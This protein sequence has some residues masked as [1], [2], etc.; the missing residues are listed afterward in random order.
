MKTSE[1]FAGRWLVTG[2]AGFI[3]SHLV[4]R[5]LREGAEVVG[6]DNL[7]TGFRSNLEGVRNAVG[8][9]WDRF[10]FI[11]GDIR[12]NEVCRSAMRGIDYV[13]HEAALGSVPRSINA[14]LDTI[15]ANVVGFCQVL[16]AAR[17]EG[18]RRF[19]YASSSSAY[20][21][22]EA[23]P[24]VEE[25]TGKPLSPYAA[26]KC[27]NE[28]FA[29]V[30]ART[31]GMTCVGLRYFNVFGPRQDP[32]GAY[33][34]VIPRWISALS[35]N[36]PVKV[37]GDG[38]TSRDF[39]YVANVTQVNLLAATHP[40]LSGHE[41]FNV[42]VGD[43]TTLLELYDLIRSSLVEAGTDVSRGVL[44]HGDFRR[45]DVRHS[46]ASIAKA[47]EVLDYRPTHDVRQGMRETIDW[48]LSSAGSNAWA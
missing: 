44:E 16:D 42:A 1:T 46:K 39:C 38:L 21:D 3:G 41:V 33:A 30:Y 22:S 15:G 10:R 31:Y 4:E 29:E 11:E 18:V 40:S 23:L 7:S 20:G 47:S 35:K 8:E 2:A 37:F 36:E 5:L 48:Y 14:P 27:C 9:H 32:N 28:T 13:L 24:K 19:V 6:L 25:V 34:A 26:T 17:L 12:D 43:Q 45:G